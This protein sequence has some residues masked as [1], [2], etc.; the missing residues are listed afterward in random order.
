[1]SPLVRDGSTFIKCLALG[2]IQHGAAV[3]SAPLPPLS[4][5]AGGEG[6]GEGGPPRLSLAAGLPHFSTGYMRNWGRDT[7]ISLPGLF[8]LTGRHA[9]ARDIILAYAGCLRY[10]NY[11]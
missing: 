4:T 9:E 3:K 7:F 6:E 5:A 1:M 8:V 10:T 2:S 11:Y